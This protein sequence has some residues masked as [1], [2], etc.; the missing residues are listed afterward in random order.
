MS[1]DN[2]PLLDVMVDTRDPPVLHHRDADNNETTSHPGR[3]TLRAI[4]ATTVYDGTLGVGAEVD[5]VSIE[6]TPDD[7]GATVAEHLRVRGSQTP[8][9][10]LMNATHPIV[11]TSDTLKVGHAWLKT[12][13]TVSYFGDV[14]GSA[15]AR[16][17]RTPT[18][19]HQTMV[20]DLT[21]CSD[22]RVHPNT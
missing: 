5:V 12:R 1:L 16:R 18:V 22:M 14:D 8:A 19:S 13:S 2:P 20:R 4:D 9:K 17:T 11:T 3:G 6:E 21:C 10:H 7:F 15:T